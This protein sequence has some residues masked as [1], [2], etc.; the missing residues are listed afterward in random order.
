M[1]LEI[2]NNVLNSLSADYDGDVLNIVPIFSQKLVNTFKV[3]SP[4]RLLI[5]ANTGSFNTEFFLEKEQRLGIYV[6]N[7][8]N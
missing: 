4:S 6:L 3:F 7:N 8:N 1:T 2:S 5:S